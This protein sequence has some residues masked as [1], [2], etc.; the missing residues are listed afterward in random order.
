MSFSSFFKKKIDCIG[1]VDIGNE[2]L[3]TAIV[4]ISPNSA[5]CLNI[6]KSAKAE[7]TY[8][9]PPNLRRYIQSVS[10][11]LDQTSKEVVDGKT[12]IPDQWFCFLPSLISINITTK[13]HHEE[14]LPIT[15]TEKMI[16]GMVQKYTNDWLT[17]INASHNIPGDKY[18]P[19]ESTVMSVALNGYTIENYHKKRAQT[20]DVALYS[21]AGSKQI[22]DLI[23]GKMQNFTHGRPIKFCTAT[24]AQ[25]QILAD[26]L[27][28]QDH[29]LLLDPSGEVCDV[30]VVHKG[31]L[32]TH[33][34]VPLG[35]RT[36]AKHNQKETAAFS[37]DMLSTLK[38]YAANQLTPT[39]REQTEQKIIAAKNIWRNLFTDVLRHVTEH[40]FVPG[41]VMILDDDALATIF[42]SWIQE[43]GF[44][45]FTL[46]RRPLDVVTITP[47]IVAAFCRAET[48]K[49]DLGFILNTLFAR[50]LSG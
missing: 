34:S 43:D 39:V 3:T 13:L 1:I 4:T 15:V 7:L 36:L 47:A 9:D 27:P 29:Y 41:S 18:V 25:Y 24:F 32:A 20:V 2:Y 45:S 6:L 46:A 42:A 35:T 50:R 10:Q 19:L 17:E 16:E 14:T 37:S 23:Q 21:S 30:T 31:V 8:G 12:T 38:L 48:S 5:E 11:A 28:N 26:L 22:I 40:S 49:Q 33:L 44:E